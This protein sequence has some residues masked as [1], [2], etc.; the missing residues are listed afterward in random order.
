M[1]LI[2]WSSLAFAA[3]LAA[4]F[5][6][7]P[8]SAQTAP[9]RCVQPDGNNA[10]LGDT[11]GPAH[12]W[13]TLE[14]ALDELNSTGGFSQIWLAKGSS[15]FKYKPHDTDT[16][17]SYSVQNP[18]EI[19]GGFQ[20][21]GSTEARTAGVRSTL[22]GDLGSTIGH[23]DRIMVIES[24]VDGPV[25]LDGL[26][27]ED[28]GSRTD[29]VA[30]GAA[31][32]ANSGVGTNVGPLTMVDCNFTGNR[33]RLRGGAVH[34]EYWA[35]VAQRCNFQ[36]NQAWGEP[37][38]GGPLGS[39][40]TPSYGGAILH[41][42]G[43]MKMANCTFV[44][45]HAINENDAA[46][47][48]E[49]GALHVLS[50]GW[51]TTI[52]NCTFRENSAHAGSNTTGKGG[53]I[54]MLHAN[55]H[56]QQAAVVNCL[57][58]GNQAG[59][60]GGALYTSGQSLLTGSTFWDNQATT[61][62]G[63]V[64][65]EKSDYEVSFPVENCIL[66][67]NL[68]GGGAFDDQL[69]ID[70]ADASLLQLRY[71]C[72]EG[73]AGSS[74]GNIAIDPEFTDPTGGD[75]RLRW[76]SPAIDAGDQSLLLADIADVDDDEDV[77]ETHPI[78]LEIGVSA[79]VKGPELDMGAFEHATV[80]ITCIADINGDGTVNGADLGLLL[81]AWGLA[82][83]QRADLNCDGTVNGADLGLLLGGWGSCGLAR[84]STMESSAEAA[85]PTPSDLMEYLGVESNEAMIEALTS[86]PFNSMT[87]LLESFLGS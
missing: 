50:K 10:N 78:D 23:S 4:S 73:H 26:V 33:A 43:R 9:Q 69:F 62:G 25:R 37:S 22:S 12:A 7:A 34:S 61:N 29:P 54:W 77:D 83:D 52:A 85:D 36:D 58:D 31:L 13:R 46:V 30:D 81:G 21:E 76:C 19:Y 3:L 56:D 82:G 28:G 41:T 5:T 66:W 84:G 24:W 38:G 70:P 74:D 6:S 45:N 79:R 42:E 60:L 53:A 17:V 2:R 87:D 48:V 63:G 1:R 47:Q 20:G 35:I 68:S 59:N 14:H 44:N 27:F 16:T 65:F 57:F 86:L 11:W 32:L 55:E 64:A 72:V 49:G 71:S 67:A 15:G 18:V 75:F 39:T 80:S 8:A 51:A 40:G